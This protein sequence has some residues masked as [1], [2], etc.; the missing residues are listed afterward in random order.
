MP[1]IIKKITVQQPS[2][3]YTEE[4]CERRI[5]FAEGLIEQR[6]QELADAKAQKKLWEQRKAQ[7][8]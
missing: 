1:K 3:E 8:K 7:C 5:E 2:V 4:Q 6:E